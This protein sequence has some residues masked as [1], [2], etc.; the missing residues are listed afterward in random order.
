MDQQGYNCSIPVSQYLITFRDGMVVMLWLIMK[1]TK[2]HK[3]NIVKQ[4]D[5]TLELKKLA[6]FIWCA[7]CF[8]IM[9]IFDVQKIYSIFS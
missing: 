7:V 9:Y 8:K 2:P 6:V 3:Q 4:T 5:E 1:A